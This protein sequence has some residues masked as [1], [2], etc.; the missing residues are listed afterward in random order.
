VKKRR[1]PRIDALIAAVS[2]RQYGVI[3][4]AQ[5]R[6]AG[7]TSAAI[8]KR[9]KAGR[10]HPQ[11]RGVYAVGH[12]RLSQQAKWLAAV[13]AAGKGAALGHQ[14]AVRHWNV[15]RRKTTA[16]DVVV[17][18]PRRPRKGFTLHRARN[19]NPKDVTIYQGIPVTTVPRTLVD[20]SATLTS[21]QLAN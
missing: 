15:W 6:A 11:Y 13:L 4:S 20:L 8:A 2:G 19:L 9:V 21:H 3:T 12:N 17:P 5:L 10:L 14:A 7:L 18:T 1:P 16:I